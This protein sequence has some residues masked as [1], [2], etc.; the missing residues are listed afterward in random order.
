[1]KKKINSI[2]VQATCILAFLMISF[3]TALAF[4]CPTT[5]CSTDCDSGD[6]CQITQYENGTLCSTTVCVG[7]GPDF[8]SNQQ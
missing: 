1:M 7:R 3:N 4:S 8:G 2:L 6:T 5:N